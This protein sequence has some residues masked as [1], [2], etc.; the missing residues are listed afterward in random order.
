M[1]IFFFSFLLLSLENSENVE[2]CREQQRISLRLHSG[3]LVL[4]KRRSSKGCNMLYCLAE[5]RAYF[6]VPRTSSATSGRGGLQ[7]TCR[8]SEAIME[9]VYDHQ[10]DHGRPEPACT[11][12]TKIARQTAPWLSCQTAAARRKGW[13]RGRKEIKM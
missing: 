9:Q 3:F 10:P 13:G 6:P 2:L 11:W 5:P 8:F 4:H 1:K 7:R 12:Q